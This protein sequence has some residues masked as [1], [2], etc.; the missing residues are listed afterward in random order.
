M[1]TFPAVVRILKS[2][3]SV[4]SVLVLLQPAWKVSVQVSDSELLTADCRRSGK[5]QVGTGSLDSLW[6]LQTS[7]FCG[8]LGALWVIELL[9]GF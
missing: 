8:E 4:W 2:S 7:R 3:Y 6:P 9:G 5:G 1:Y